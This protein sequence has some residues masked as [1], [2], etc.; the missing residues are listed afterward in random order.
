[1]S[2]ARI[3]CVKPEMVATYHLGVP[4]GFECLIVDN[5]IAVAHACQILN[6]PLVSMSNSPLVEWLSEDADKALAK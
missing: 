4:A 6:I 1:M 3:F 5:L 2:G